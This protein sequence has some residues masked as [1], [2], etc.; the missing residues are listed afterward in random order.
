M[1]ENDVIKPC[2]GESCYN[3]RRCKKRERNASF[4]KQDTSR[5]IMIELQARAFSALTWAIFWGVLPS[6]APPNLLRLFFFFWQ[7]HKPVY[8]PNHCLVSVLCTWIF[9]LC[10]FWFSLSF[11]SKDS[12]EKVLFWG[13]SCFFWFC[14]SAFIVIYIFPFLWTEAVFFCTGTVST[15]AKKN[16]PVHFDF[17][18]RFPFL[19][20]KREGRMC[21]WC[22]LR[23][24]EIGSNGVLRD[25]EKS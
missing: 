22:W 17:I 2:S 18:H 7:Y 13:Y 4:K 16:S 19:D 20:Y 23:I 25:V 6:M 15:H 1:E 21:A 12:L 5:N 9:S 10:Y 11:G 24:R 14:F 3:N 8:R